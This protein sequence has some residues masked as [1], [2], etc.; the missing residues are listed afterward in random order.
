MLVELGTLGLLGRQPQKGAFVLTDLDD[1]Y[2][3][4]E[5]KTPL[6]ER[7]QGHGS[8]TP[9][10][11]FRSSAVI[12]VKGWFRGSSHAEAV[13]AKS[14]LNGIGAGALVRMTV[15]DEGVT[16]R[17]VSVRRVDILDD[18]G[19]K[20]FHF[21]IDCLAPDPRRY[22]PL[23][24]QVVAGQGGNLISNP[25]FETNTAGWVVHRTG[26]A[27]TVLTRKTTTPRSGVGFGSWTAAAA[28]ELVSFETFSQAVH[29][30]GVDTYVAWVRASTPRKVALTVT[31]LSAAGAQLVTWSQSKVLL[32]NTWTR[33]LITAGAEL[34]AAVASLSLAVDAAGVVPGETIDVD[35]ALVSSTATEVYPLPVP[36]A[37]LPAVVV[38]NTGTADTRPVLVVTAGQSLPDGFSVVEIN[39]DGPDPLYR[40]IS[41]FPALA[42]GDVVAL[43]PEVG[44]ALLNGAPTPGL[45]NT[46]WPIVPPGATR[47]YSFNTFNR[48][49]HLQVLSREAWW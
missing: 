29:T 18:H 21:V 49:G 2:S 24:S 40:R 9:G 23:V 16:T 14:V 44:M 41:Y 12:T 6:N 36:F 27:D 7:P 25:G 42:A 48:V 28:Y 19:R 26:A 30:F 15:T 4:S 31:A 34:P 1:W 5:S 11:D 37:A 20:Q 10:P 39:N 33:I 8:F 32:A 43:N 45:W 38:T 13:A 46:D 47:V 17:L 3:L 22:G 35:D